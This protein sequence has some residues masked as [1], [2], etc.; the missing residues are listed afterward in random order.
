MTLSFRDV[1]A[2]IDPIRPPTRLRGTPGNP[3][4]GSRRDQREWLHGGDVARQRAYDFGLFHD[5]EK[6]LFEVHRGDVTSL[7]E[8]LERHDGPASTSHRLLALNTALLWISHDE[9]RAR[10]KDIG[11]TIGREGYDVACLCEVFGPEEVGLIRDRV[12]DYGEPAWEEAFGPPDSFWHTSGG[13][14]GL[15]G[16]DDRDLVGSAQETYSDGG[17]GADEWA[18]KGWLR[19][20]IDLGPG[21][22]DVFLTHA[23]ASRGS[24]NVSDRKQ[25]LR[26]LTDAIA[27]RQRDCPGHVTMAVGDFNVYSE[28]D[29]YEW[30]LERMAET[31]SLR[32]AW[33]TSGG[34]AGATRAFSHCSFGPPDCACDDYEST[35]YGKNRLDYVFVQDP[36]PEHDFQLDIGRVRRRPFPRAAPCGDVDPADLADD[37]Y[38]Y[39]SDHLGLDVEL[40]ASP[41]S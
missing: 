15:V 30:F 17:A 11:R 7:R 31:C 5:R 18:N 13:L 41:T 21:T 37:E 40:F 2:R 32:D 39:V 23:N 1:A 10:A 29:E 22:L 6:G 25:Q 20:E 19:M 4:L 3:D 35:D 9:L 14:Y 12:D 24:T 38:D 36:H 26:E 27:Q 33:L 8:V 34:K 16:G 28:D